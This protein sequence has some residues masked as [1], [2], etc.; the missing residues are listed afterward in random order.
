MINACL[1]KA[2]KLACKRHIIMGF[3]VQGLSSVYPGTKTFVLK[4]YELIVQLQISHKMRNRLP[5]WQ[6]MI[7][8]ER[9]TFSI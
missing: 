2:L 6:M 5:R 4:W 1:F 9:E 8:I 7:Y 3:C